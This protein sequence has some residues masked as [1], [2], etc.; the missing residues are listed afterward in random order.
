MIIT[1]SGDPGSGKSTIAK[2]IAK[3][4]GLK[5]YSAG[6]FVRD[7]AK[8]KGITL[9]E[10]CALA[11]KNPKI[12]QEIDLRNKTLAEKEDDFVIDSRLAWHF[13]P[14]SIKIYLKCD[15]TE[16]A[17]RVFPRKQK[18][19]EENITL[20]KTKENIIKREQSEIER[21]QNYY[22]INLKD[23]SNYDLVLDTTNHT[24][25]E[26]IKKVL[27]WISQKIK[28]KEQIR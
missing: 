4:F 2:A 21:Y 1:I 5:H 3:H 8:E 22:G 17:K 27:E 11:E 26:V 7:L 16:A 20:E 23:K 24:K 15:A 14:D 10:L 6:D 13:M 18:G 19:D 9:L 28:K 12:D 25:E